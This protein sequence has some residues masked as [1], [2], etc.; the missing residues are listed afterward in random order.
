M[1]QVL[2]A[3]VIVEGVE[4]HNPLNE[5]SILWITESRSPLGLI[6]EIFGPVK[7]PYYVVRY[8][9]DSEVP[10]GIQ[11]GTSISFVQE[12]ANH[13][14]NDNNLYKKGY[15]MSGENDEELSE[16]LEFSDDEKEAEYRR[17]QK[18]E[19]RGMSDQKPNRKMNKKKIRNREGAFHN[20]S[21]SVHQNQFQNQISSPASES[22][23]PSPCSPAGQGFI[24]GTDLV[25]QLQQM[26]QMAGYGPSFNG[27]WT[28]GMPYQQTQNV[29]PGGFQSS[30]GM[31]WIPQ[32]NQQQHPNQIPMMNNMPF[33]QQFDPT[34]MALPNVGLASGQPNFFPGHT[35]APWLG[36]MGQNGLN[37]MMGM[38]IP[39]Q[40]PLN[41]GQ[42]QMSGMGF[43]GQPGAQAT[44]AGESFKSP[45]GPSQFNMG[46]SSRGGR[47]PYRRGGGDGGGRGRGYSR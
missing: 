1:L 15:D 42:P 27:V 16:E 34:Q 17:K 10:A 41:A 45:R 46:A 38:G 25:P 39:G 21:L 3:Q 23:N 22:G 24:G 2:G 14:L 36:L 37:P 32:N 6:D 43:P 8:N 19:K 35:F 20:N 9:S 12:F 11:V 31:P 40:P 7:N 47:K 18:M 4:K 30:G 44:N 28:N 29:F 5:G 33:M 26:A 13:V